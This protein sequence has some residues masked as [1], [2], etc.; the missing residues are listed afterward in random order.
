MV[1][2][3]GNLIM[4]GFL[5]KVAEHVRQHR[6]IPASAVAE[7]RR[8]ALAVPP[9]EDFLAR[10]DD[11]G[12]FNIIAEVKYASPSQGTIVAQA[13]EERQPETV[14]T[15]YF[16]AGAKAVSVLTEP[17]WFQGDLRYLGR[18]R[19]TLP[20]ANL[21]MKDFVIDES[22]VYQA[23][24]YQAN[25]VLLIVAMLSPQRLAA[26]HA[27]AIDLRLTPL[28]EVHDEAELAAA[29]KIK[30]R[31]LG[32]NNRNLQTLKIDLETGLRLRRR[33]PAG[34][35]SVCESGIETPQDLAR[36]RQ[37]GF[38]TFLVGTSL[39]RGG[40]PGGALQRLLDGAR[41]DYEK[42]GDPS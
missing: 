32:V 11:A 17:Q 35:R 34:I 2:F 30:P 25:A 37:G 19:S 40:D 38:D 14:A 42:T 13:P 1:V 33:I 29:L 26:L 12:G 5:D 27:L 24:L 36:M 15:A 9:P 16:A 39:M 18:I 22:Q 23:R 21:L 28:V 6:L 4:G 10:L 41:H 7:L 20:R 3:K 31:L 8:Q